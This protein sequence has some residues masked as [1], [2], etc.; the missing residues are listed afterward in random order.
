MPL[1]SAA[2]EQGS[3]EEGVMCEADP[4]HAELMI[5]FMGMMQGWPLLTPD[6]KEV[7]GHDEDEE[8][9][10]QERSKYGAMAAEANYLVFRLV[11]K[12]SHLRQLWLCGCVVVGFGVC[13]V[14]WW[15][16]R[17]CPVDLPDCSSYVTSVTQQKS[18]WK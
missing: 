5:E 11:D 14:W 6:M 9:A 7:K 8:L 16:S 1:N 10:A 12:T 3:D 4:R 2:W 13:D 17:R 15:W 18:Y